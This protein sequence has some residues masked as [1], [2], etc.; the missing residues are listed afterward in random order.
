MATSPIQWEAR[1]TGGSRFADGSAII[2]PKELPWTEGPVE[3]VSFRLT[4]VDR[5]TGMW[6]ALFKMD[7]GVEMPAYFNYG[8][9]QFYVIEG[10][11]SVDDISLG[12]GHYYQDFS[13][14]ARA[15]R[16]G[17]SGVIFFVMFAGGLALADGDG[18][19]SGPY[20]DANRIYEVAAEN[21]AADHLPPQLLEQ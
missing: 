19:P 1:F 11:M 8:E 21:G 5:V 6:T 17:P 2:R 13:G 3:G 14:P 12:L 18:K 16:A 10:A 4:H 9:V 7:A 15:T 20:I